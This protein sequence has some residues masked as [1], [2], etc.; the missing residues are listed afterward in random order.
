M[1]SFFINRQYP[2]AIVDRT[3]KKALSIDRITALTPKT[4]SASDRIP[5]KITFHPVNNSIKPIVNRNFNLLNS[6]SSTSNIFNQRPLFFF[7]ETDRNL[8][9]FLFKKTLPSN[10]EPS[11][12]RCSRKRCLTCSFVVS[13]TAVTAPSPLFTLSNISIAQHLILF[14]EFNALTAISYT[15]VKLAAIQMIASE[16]TFTTYART[17]NLNLSLAILILLIILFLILQHLVFLSSTAVTIV[18]RLKKCD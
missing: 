12:F 11:T 2:A 17:I 13:R 9:N 14:I 16:I 15:S 4:R 18:A 8:R 1:R 3:M 10:K 6:Y 7:Q 5:F